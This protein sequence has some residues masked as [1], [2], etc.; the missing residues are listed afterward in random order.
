[1]RKKRPTLQTPRR[2]LVCGFC[3][4]CCKG[5]RRLRI[6]EPAVR[7]KTFE[8]HGVTFLATAPN[9]DCYYLG[10]AG[11]SIYDE[12][13]EAC[14]RFDCRDYLDNPMLALRLRLPAAQR[15]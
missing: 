5:P 3:R 4:E 15:L 12:R 2:P 7:F 9:G 14:R 10:P 8:E 1:M 11:C 13:P 6:D